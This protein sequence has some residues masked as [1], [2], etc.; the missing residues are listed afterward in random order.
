MTM[1]L[2][3][4]ASNGIKAAVNT[5]DLPKR[6]KLETTLTI[7]AKCRLCRRYEPGNFFRVVR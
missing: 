4:A 5:D 3:E 2:L 1:E 7:V 6:D